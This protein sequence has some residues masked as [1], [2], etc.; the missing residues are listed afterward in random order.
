METAVT[1]TVPRP[2][3][4]PLLRRPPSR[5]RNSANASGLSPVT[6]LF[7][8]SHDLITTSYYVTQFGS[9]LAEIGTLLDC[10]GCKSYSLYSI[11]QISSHILMLFLFDY[12]RICIINRR[13]RI[14]IKIL[15]SY[16]IEHRVIQF[17]NKLMQFSSL[18]KRFESVIRGQEQPPQQ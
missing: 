8:K 3:P 11:V 4:V 1:V 5:Q 17:E 6:P 7:Q 18:T 13:Q 14:N 10:L 15:R 16:R 2:R 12:R 9:K